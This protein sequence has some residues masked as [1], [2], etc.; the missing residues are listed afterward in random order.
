VDPGRD[1]WN[2]YAYVGNNPIVYRDLNGLE[3]Y[4]IVVGDAGLGEHNVGENFQRAAETRQSELESEGHTVDVVN[5]S[6]VTE[7][8]EA[9]SNG[10]E[11]DGGLIYIGHGSYNALYIGENEGDDTN[12]TEANIS[13]LSND[14]LS[15]GCTVQLLA[16]YTGSGASQSIAQRIAD[17][18]DRPVIAPSL[19]LS[20]SSDPTT[21][22]SAPGERP[23]NTGPLYMVMN[24]RGKYFVLRPRQ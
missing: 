19:D 22:L 2:L 20:F 16:C 5:V 3:R 18:L 23:P 15:A 11:I 12:L 14:N 7:F 13:S 17:Q 9:M 6:A 8:N 24:P 21:Y 4:L 10:D 1:G